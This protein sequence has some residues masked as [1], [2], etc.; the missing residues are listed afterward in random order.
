METC[1]MTLYQGQ[2]TPS[3]R[4]PEDRVLT[5]LLCGLRYGLCALGRIR[6]L[7]RH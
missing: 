5:C 3:V 6:H 1:Q 7:V 4:T 2:F